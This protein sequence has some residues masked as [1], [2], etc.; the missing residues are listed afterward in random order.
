M[1]IYDRF[2][3]AKKSVQISSL[4]DHIEL[5]RYYIVDKNGKSR[6][7][8]D[9]LVDLG[10]EKQIL[11]DLLSPKNDS[12]QQL[13]NQFN[14]DIS[15]NTGDVF[16]VIPLIQEVTKKVTLNSFEER[17]KEELFHL[18]EII[19]QPHFLLTRYVEARSLG[20]LLCIFYVI[21]RIQGDLWKRMSCVCP[22]RSS[23][24]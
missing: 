6:D 13:F 16:E 20:L 7:L 22:G 9:K 1:L 19:R 24:M 5:G 14:S 12:T 4:P 21:Q 11:Q 17:L 3:S 18:E 15:G 8:T 10:T 23:H 2:T